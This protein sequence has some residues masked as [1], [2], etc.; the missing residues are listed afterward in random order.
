MTLP[1]I[2]GVSIFCVIAIM[3]IAYQILKCAG[4]DMKNFF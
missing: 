3:Y 2:A 1:E 4:Y